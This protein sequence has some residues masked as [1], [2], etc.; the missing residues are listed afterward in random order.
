MGSIQ[1]SNVS[2]IPI[3]EPW[4]L[5]ATMEKEKETGHYT[6]LIRVSSNEWVEVNDD[7]SLNV[8]RFPENLSNVT[9]LCFEKSI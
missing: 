7:A 1:T 2:S 8:A 3:T 4:Q 6:A 9:C 5:S